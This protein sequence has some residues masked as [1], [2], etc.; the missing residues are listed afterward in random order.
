MKDKV[1]DFM[2]KYVL[3]KSNSKTPEIATNDQTENKSVTQSGD[4][5]SSKKKTT[6]I[7]RIIDDKCADSACFSAGCLRIFKVSHIKD[8]INISSQH[9][10]QLFINCFSMTFIAE[11]GDRSQLATIVLAGINNV[12][13]VIIGLWPRKYLNTKVNQ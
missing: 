5:T 1:V 9:Y 3:A 6:F 12:W 7:D 13:G 10:S 2:H 11:W 8:I 4:K